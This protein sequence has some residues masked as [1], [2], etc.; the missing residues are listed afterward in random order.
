MTATFK[1]PTVPS[2]EARF[3]AEQKL[4]EDGRVVPL[5]HVPQIMGLGPRVRR[6]QAGPVERVPGRGQGVLDVGGARPA[7]L[8]DQAPVVRAPDLEGGLPPA[9]GAGHEERLGPSHAQ[10]PVPPRAGGAHH[11]VTNGRPAPSPTGWSGST[12]ISWRAAPMSGSA[13]AGRQ[14]RRRW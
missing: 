8:A 9:P 6:L 2:P 12:P 14:R 1:A 5:F 10:R 4:L 13:S 7:H 11:S 3:E